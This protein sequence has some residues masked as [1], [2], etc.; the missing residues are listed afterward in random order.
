MNISELI[1][2]LLRQGKNVELQG[3]G[4]LKSVLKEP[5]MDPNTNT[6][7]PATHTVVLDEAQSGDTTAIEELA[8]RECVSTNVAS[9]MWRNYIDALTDKVSTAGSHTFNGLGTIAKN[10]NRYSFSAAD[11]LMLDTTND[12]EMPLK[13]VKIYNHDDEA[14]PFAKFD[15]PQDDEEA[16][17]AEQ[18]RLEAER[19]EAERKAEE[20]RLEA[21]RLE[22]ERKAEEDRLEAERLEAERKAEEE[23]LEAER[24]E[25]ERKAEE[26][27]LEAERLEA[28]RKAEEERLEAERLEAERKAEEERLEAERLE[29][30]RKAEAEREAEEERIAAELRA[31][32]ER[33]AEEARI[34]AEE[35]RRIDELASIDNTPKTVAKK[36]KNGDGEGRKKRFGWIWIVIILLLAIIALLCWRYCSGRPTSQPMVTDTAANTNLS[37]I[38]AVNSLTFNTDL[39]EYSDSEMMQNSDFVCYTL[40][41]YINEYLADRGYTGALAAMME[42]VRQY[43]SQRMSELLGPRFAVQRFIPYDDYI[44]LHNEPC[45]R[46]VYAKRSRVQVQSELMEYNLLDEILF[47][48]VEELGLQP[49]AGQPRTADEVRQVKAEERRVIEERQNGNGKNKPVTVN[50]ANDSKQGFDIIAGCYLNRATASNLTAKLHELGCDAYI[51]E[52]NDLYYVSMGSSPTRTAADALYRHIKSWYDGDIVI[53]EW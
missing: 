53:K 40:A 34:E 44:Y 45:L 49:D 23:R 29:A 24:L 6:Y 39:I 52:K 18:E 21:E 35:K 47:R 38:T 31:E 20:E 12:R 7:Y 11:D 43:S 4:T 51:I 1:V 48:M 37:D 22:A 14:D 13:D 27:R 42:R 8:A 28:E 15:N 41:P 10:D 25:A 46:N 2:E 30:E 17:R 19:L 5:Y 3:I 50:V 36:E 9:Q 16:L 33:K 26:E 32:D